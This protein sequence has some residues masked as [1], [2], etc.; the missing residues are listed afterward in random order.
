[1]SLMSSRLKHTRMLPP[2]KVITFYGISTNATSPRPAAR[3]VRLPKLLNLVLEHA[4]FLLD[5]CCK[6]DKYL[7]SYMLAEADESRPVDRCMDL[8]ELPLGI[9]TKPKKC[10]CRDAGNNPWKGFRWLCR[11]A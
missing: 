8:S 5:S 11:T 10:R 2:D 1:M 6:F 3:G 9:Q 4:T 7:F